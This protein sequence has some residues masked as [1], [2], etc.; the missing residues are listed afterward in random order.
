MFSLLRRFIK[1]ERGAAG[2]I[3][4]LSMM[5]LI[6]ATGASIDYAR[7]QMVQGKLAD[8]LDAAGLAAGATLSSQNVRDVV[9]NYFDVNFPQG[10]MDAAIDP[11]QVNINDQQTVLTLNA[12]AHVPTIFMRIAGI[13]EMNVT[14]ETEITRKSGGMELVL[15][16]DNTGSMAGSKLTSLKSAATELINILFGDDETKEKLWVGLVPFSQAVNIGSDYASWINQSHFN[17]LNWRGVPWAG[18]VDARDGYDTTDDPPSTLLFNAYYWRDDSNNDWLRNNGNLQSGIGVNKGPN[19]YCPQRV[20]EMSNSKSTIL[21]GINSMQAVGNTHVNLG[22]VWGWRMLSPRW[23]GV[24]GSTM[25]ENSLPLDYGTPHM[26]KV[27]ILLTDGENT[28]SS[29]VRTAYGYPSEGRLGTTSTSTAVTRLNERLTTTCNNMKNAGIKVYSIM[30]DL[31]SSSV[32][33]LFK[34]CASQ[35]D[36]YFDTPTSD[37]LHQAFR[38]IGDSLS[39]LRISK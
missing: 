35:P 30:F 18:C 1:D 9:E 19:K 5:S 14:A 15:V 31:N 32:S 3:I 29:T 28:M 39:N 34:G 27:V 8:T 38:T 20:T 4:A 16:M 2:P 11:V 17:S 10:Y 12:T 26:T 33:K 25:A 7:G 13:D 6:M 24:W 36:Y 22:A 37:E 23:R 21:A